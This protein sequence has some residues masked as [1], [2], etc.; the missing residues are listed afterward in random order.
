MQ[1]GKFP[2]KPQVKLLVIGSLKL[3]LPYFNDAKLSAYVNL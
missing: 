3:R 2:Q 1:L